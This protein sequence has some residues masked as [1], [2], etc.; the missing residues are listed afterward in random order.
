MADPVFLLKNITKRLTVL[1]SKRYS[2]SHVG[3]IY[4][5]LK[6]LTFSQ[7]AQGIQ[8]VLMGR[9]SNLKQLLYSRFV[10]L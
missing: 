2:N 6:L 10:V 4:C 5:N 9:T 3:S 7:Q 1:L 8:N